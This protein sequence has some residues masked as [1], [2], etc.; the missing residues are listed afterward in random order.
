M[1]KYGA[2][3]KGIEFMCF[4]PA[5]NALSS[6]YPDL[7]TRAFKKRV[8][9]EFKAMLQRTPDVGGSFLE[10]NLYVA[11]FV[12]SFYKADEERVTPEI[13]DK[14]VDSVFDSPLLVK[15]HKLKKCTLFDEEVQNVKL[16]KSKDSQNSKYEL[17]WKF[18]YVKG[19]N[20]FFNTFTE[21]GICKL[22]LR[23]NCFQFVPCLC[24][25]DERHYRLEGGELHRTK[26]IANGDDC[27]DFH[28]VKI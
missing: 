14:M 16:E 9:Q 4:K 11:A 27:C 12:F 1:L 18:E 28:V 24:N 7:N 20:E 2:L 25:M 26:T 10:S 23:E 5:L 22:G 15:L 13:V 19:E 8:K 17:D 21:C 3:A 6:A